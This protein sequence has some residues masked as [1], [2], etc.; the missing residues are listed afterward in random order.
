MPFLI[1]AKTKK[2][3]TCHERMEGDSPGA[4]KRGTVKVLLSAGAAT[5]SGKVSASADSGRTRFS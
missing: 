3:H 5:V 2:V 4:K 1:S